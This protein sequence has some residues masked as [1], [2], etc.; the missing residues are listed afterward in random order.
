MGAPRAWTAVSGQTTDGTE[1]TIVGEEALRKVRFDPAFARIELD[2]TVAPPRVVV[3]A[4]PAA[5]DVVGLIVALTARVTALEAKQ[6]TTTSLKVADYVAVAW[7]HVLM[8]LASAGSMSVTL[9]ASSAPTAGARVRVSDVSPYSGETLSIVCTFYSPAGGY[10]ATSPH[11]VADDG[12][13]VSLEG[14]SIELL[15]TGAGWVIVSDTCLP[16]QLV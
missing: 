13:G 12:A 15:D 4:A 7:E 14:A 3:S 8:S 2:S 6:F 10:Y 1:R 9:P 5:V 11:V 16:A